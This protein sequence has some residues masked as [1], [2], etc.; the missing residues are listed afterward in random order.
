LPRKIVSIQNALTRVEALTALR[1][2]WAADRRPPA[3]GIVKVEVL[4][5]YQG[6]LGRRVEASYGKPA[7]S[8]EF[9]SDLVSAI[10]NDIER[11]LKDANRDLED[12]EREAS[13]RE[14]FGHGE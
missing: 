3:G 10:L 4:G 1:A 7:E 11:D 12:A 5:P 8:L 6:E 14:Y 9:A 2:R 13:E